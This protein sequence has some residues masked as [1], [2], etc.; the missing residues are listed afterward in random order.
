MKKTTYLPPSRRRRKRSVLLRLLAALL[1]FGAALISI[2]R[3]IYPL[4]RDFAEAEAAIR[5]NQLINEAV[6]DYFSQSGVAYT[7]LVI[8]K[9]N[10]Q[11][12]IDAAEANT[13]RINQIKTSVVEQVRARVL[14]EEAS[15]VSIPLGNL[16]GLSYLAGRGPVIR[17]RLRM[18]SNVTASFESS[19]TS[20][21]INQTMHSITLRVTADMYIMLPTGRDASSFSTD[22]LVGQTLIVGAVPE[23]FAS[24]DLNGDSNLG[25][26]VSAGETD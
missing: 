19:F 25:K 8:L 9:R 4:I 7:D 15:T 23:T 24:I 13:I 14:E 11:G 20:A 10:G 22:Y 12:Q 18:S 1:I 3:R 5:A 2:D 17:V 26:L 21:G 6:A 16:T